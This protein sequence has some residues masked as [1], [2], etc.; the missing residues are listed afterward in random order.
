MEEV[1]IDVRYNVPSKYDSAPHATIAKVVTGL[2][3]DN[4]TYKY[5]IQASKNDQQPEWMCMGD[6]LEIAL[7]TL[8][9]RQAFVDETS[10]M[11]QLERI[12][13]KSVFK[14]S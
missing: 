5:Y 8:F 7:E 12:K 14:R 10:L 6:F 9:T 11:Y 4:E 13:K 3:K 2:G 1:E